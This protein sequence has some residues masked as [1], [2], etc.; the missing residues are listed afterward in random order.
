MFESF[1]LLS[2]IFRAIYKIILKGK[3]KEHF[4]LKE[5]ILMEKVKDNF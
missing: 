2:L 5:N 1:F 4:T 3:V